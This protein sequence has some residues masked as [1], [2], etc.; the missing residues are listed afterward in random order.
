MKSEEFLKSK[1]FTSL[2]LNSSIIIG[3][4]I[5]LITLNISIAK[6]PNFCFCIVT[7]LSPSNSFSNVECLSFYMVSKH[8]SRRQ[9]FLL[10]FINSYV[11]DPNQRTTTKLRHEI[12]IH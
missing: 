10:L 4:E 11:A 1:R 2:Q 7:E 12:R 8:H 9:L 5:K 6:K 3:T